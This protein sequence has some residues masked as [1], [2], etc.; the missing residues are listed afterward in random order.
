MCSGNVASLFIK[1][2]MVFAGRVGVI[3]G[4]CI[5][6]VKPGITQE[7]WKKEHR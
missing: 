6:F 3:G 2:I 4:G 7:F 1:D 5:I